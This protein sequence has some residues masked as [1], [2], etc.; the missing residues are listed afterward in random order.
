MAASHVI[1]VTELT[2]ILFQISVGP[3]GGNCG[4]Q[5]VTAALLDP[6]RKKNSSQERSRAPFWMW[7]SKSKGEQVQPLGALLWSK[8]TWNELGLRYPGGLQINILMP[9]PL[10]LL[11]E[12]VRTSLWN[13]L[14]SEKL[15]RPRVPTLPPHTYL[16]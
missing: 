16:V 2:V 8:P 15:R 9:D 6:L 13:R 10:C 12:G 11:V 1:Y 5:E 14:G 3:N 7:Q 4:H